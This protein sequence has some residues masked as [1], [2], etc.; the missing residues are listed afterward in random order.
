MDAN[1]LHELEHSVVFSPHCI[2]V[3]AWVFV[4]H[5]LVKKVLYASVKIS[6]ALGAGEKTECKFLTLP[7]LDVRWR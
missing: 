2:F 1:R 5:V 3:K 6:V 7:A 4:F